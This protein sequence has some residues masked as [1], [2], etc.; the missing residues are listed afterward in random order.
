MSEN[1]KKNFCSTNC[2]KIDLCSILL[3]YWLLNSLRISF[4]KYRKP[5]KAYSQSII[6]V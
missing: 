1:D 2:S 6:K 4:P 3:P 5:K